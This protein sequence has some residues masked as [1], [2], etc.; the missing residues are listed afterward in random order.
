MSKRRYSA[1]EAAQIIANLRNIREE[2]SGDDDENDLNE[3]RIDSDYSN[4]SDD[5]SSSESSDEVEDSDEERNPAPS[6][7][8][9][10]NRNTAR[11][12]MAAQRVLSRR[13]R[14]RGAMNAIHGNRNNLSSRNATVWQLKTDNGNHRGRAANHNILRMH[15]GPTPYASQGINMDSPLSAFRVLFDEPM[16]RHVKECTEREGKRIQGEDWSISLQE[17]EVFLGLFIARG[18]VG[19]RTAPLSELWSAKWG[20]RFFK[21]AMA[22]DRYFEIQRFLRFD[23]RDQRRARL[24]TNKFAHI[25]EV[26]QRFIDNCQRAYSPNSTLTID[27]QLLPSKCRCPFIQYISTKPDKFEIEF[28]LMVDSTSKYL[29]NGF[30]YLG[31]D[32]AANAQMSLPSRVVLKLIEPLRPGHHI[33]MDNF[34]TSLDLA[35][36]LLNKGRT[37]LGTWTLLCND[38]RRRTTLFVLHSYFVR[39]TLQSFG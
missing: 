20:N 28:F 21:N 2:E 32:D 25:S 22:R 26:W 24:Q 3:T 18:V 16:L 36:Q 12:M 37:L 10:E 31:R 35:K 15:P 14:G 19:S 5:S 29:F 27:E 6:A 9:S 30:P 34:F 17:L 13:G 7:S 39:V 23:N 1:T 11:G 8:T 4:H 38:D 33:S